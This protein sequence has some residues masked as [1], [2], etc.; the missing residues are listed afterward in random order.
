LP[1]SRWLIGFSILLVLAVVSLAVWSWKP[2]VDRLG[3][4]QDATENSDPNLRGDDAR[5]AE[6]GS[7]PGLE[8]QMDE[9]RR[10]SQELESELRKPSRPSNSNDSAL[11]WLIEAQQR[12]EKLERELSPSTP[13]K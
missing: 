8:N 11:P 3:S 13:N 6:P 9:I 5:S 2:L 1:R 10:Q 7:E 4:A 12:L